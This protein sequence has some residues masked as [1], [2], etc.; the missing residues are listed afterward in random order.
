[1]RSSLAHA[2][3]ALQCLVGS[4]WSAAPLVALR[5][6]V[7][8]RAGVEAGTEMAIVVAI[9]PEDRGRLGQRAF[10][11]TTL[12][13]GETV[14]ES[15]QQVVD[16]VDGRTEVVAIW[17]PGRYDLRV[18]VEGSGGGQRGFWVG[19]VDVLR[20]AP[21][22]T[23]HPS[24]TA[25][26]LPTVAPTTPPSASP[27]APLA[28]AAAP[29]APAPPASP[30]LQ[31]ALQPTSPP[32]PP[33][34]V[35]AAA[36]ASAGSRPC[37][38]TLLAM[39]GRNQPLRDLTRDELALELAG[40]PATVT[41]F[42]GAGAPLHL[43]FVVAAPD[44]LATFATASR[45]AVVRLAEAAI[46]SG[47][48]VLLQEAAGEV[49]W[50]TDAPTLD[51]RLVAADQGPTPVPARVVAALARLAE[52]GGRRALVVI[53]GAGDDSERTAWDAASTAAAA[54]G[55]PILTMVAAG[56]DLPQR[57]RARVRDL[58]EQSGG[59]SYTLRGEDLVDLTTALYRGLLEASVSLAVVA[60]VG[61]DPV[62]VKVATSR[63]GVELSSSAALACR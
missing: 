10:L 9:A 7:T 46:G 23:A 20:L 45:R 41:G 22:P 58:A 2:V 43:A 1:M 32:T 63:D 48:Q 33:P 57:L 54:G 50:T 34:R 31:P 4:A 25:T 21:R 17:P 28:V 49:A 15:S 37:S 3:V 16:L 5:V 6:E 13:V 26:P 14:R 55:T 12:S 40:Q 44:E 60:P 39:D 38:L 47:G 30:P 52:V 24:A 56:D 53:V 61:T 8:A 11:T 62:R 36:V 18:D 42:A 27:A 51:H 59:R 19:A 35:A 29:I